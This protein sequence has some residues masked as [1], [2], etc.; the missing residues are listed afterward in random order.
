MRGI[1]VLAAPVLFVLTSCST[2]QAQVE[3][4]HFEALVA[5][6]QAE[7]DSIHAAGSFPGATVTLVL[8]DGRE[9]QLAVGV[10]EE[11]GR[12]LTADDRMLVGSVG[13][14]WVAALAHQLVEEGSFDYD[15]RVSEWFTG[16]DW[17]SRIPNAADVTIRQLLRHQSGFERYE[18]KMEFWQELMLDP[19]RVW[20]PEELLAFVL[21][22][23]PMFAAGE[24]WAYSD[25][26]YIL[27]GMIIERASG[28]PFYER[29][30]DQINRP[31]DLN[32]TIPSDQRRLPGVVQGTVAIGQQ[33]GVG[34]R[35]LEDGE[36]TYNVQ[37]EWCGGGFAST[38]TDLA[39]WAGLLYSERLL[40][41]E[42][43]DAMLD[44]VPAPELG[45]GRSYGLGVIVTDTRLGPL[46]GH[47]GFMPGYLTA[48]GYFPD[49]GVAAA[50]QVNTDDGR[51]VG[52]PLHEVM[53][54]LVELTQ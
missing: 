13:K 36:F 44:V 43:L 5:A 35:T 47:D 46:R 27:L 41:V 42:G 33:L 6:C 26:N 3:D 16:D 19:D 21:D 8:E 48:M 1:L 30:H 7:L 2:P 4:P 34:P 9:I 52:M 51:A 22:D 38:S 20:K 12:P 50:I 11:G 37:F 40:G 24:G 39:R 18:F 17:Y 10:T 23:E 49:L 45:P 31:H 25:T 14:T 53:I 29:V 28:E 54:R 32:D 15:D